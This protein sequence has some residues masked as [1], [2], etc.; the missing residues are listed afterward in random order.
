VYC[1]PGGRAGKLAAPAD[2]DQIPGIIG[3]ARLPGHGK[4]QARRRTH[5]PSGPG[6]ATG[7]AGLSC[8]AKRGRC[9]LVVHVPAAAGDRAQHGLVPEQRLHPQRGPGHPVAD[10]CL[11]PQ[12][13]LLPGGADDLV[14]CQ[15]ERGDA[16]FWVLAVSPAVFGGGVPAVELPA[17]P[18]GD[19]GRGQQSVVPPPPGALLTVRPDGRDLYADAGQA[20]GG[21]A[22]VEPFRQRLGGEYHR[23][24][25]RLR[26]VELA[27]HGQ[28]RGRR[29]GRQRPGV[30]A[31]G[32]PVRGLPQVAEPAGHVAGGQRGEIAEGTQAQ[33]DQQPSQILTGR[34]PVGRGLSGCGLSVRRLSRRV[35][36]CGLS[37]CGLSGCGLSGQ[38][39]HRL[40][41]Q[42]PWR[43]AGRD[44][45]DRGV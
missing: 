23:L 7:Q 19:G 39:A 18:F 24:G 27:G 43:P 33:P 36:G 42:E 4:D 21:E 2:R 9:Y 40:G 10:G 37:G 22:V 44:H 35:S 8:R 26:R 6:P 29:G 12:C 25:P 34:F 13:E 1:Q 17:D 16:A 32:Q 41:R 30:Q 3:H 38:D 15:L 14:G 31:A 20:A 5:D 28:V 45:R 11:S